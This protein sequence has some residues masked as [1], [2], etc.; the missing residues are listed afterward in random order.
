MPKLDYAQQQFHLTPLL[1]DLDDGAAEDDLQGDEELLNAS[2]LI[3]SEP[4]ESE[5]SDVLLDESSLETI[6][7]MLAVMNSIE[8]LLM[9]EALTEAQKRQVWSATPENIR[10]KLKQIREAG[11]STS[12]HWQAE[13]NQSH[14]S[15]LSVGDQ[16][17]LMAKPKLAAAELVAV[18]DVVAVHEGYARI[19]AKNLGVRNYPITW[20]VVYP[21][22][23]SDRT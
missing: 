21:G 23:P 8:E 4:D 12:E 7:D 13:W 1:F 22:T 15:P 11:F 14:Q 18:W 5:Y 2:H 10:S 20:M 3:A 17:V 19:K 9:L 16:V 6:L